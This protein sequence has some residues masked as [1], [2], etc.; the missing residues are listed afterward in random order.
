MLVFFSPFNN[1]IMHVLCLYAYFNIFRTRTGFVNDAQAK[2]RKQWRGN[3]KRWTSCLT[4]CRLE[5]P[6][7]GNGGEEGAPSQKLK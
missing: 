2:R 3:L 1:K 6:R 4:Y 5:A 7:G